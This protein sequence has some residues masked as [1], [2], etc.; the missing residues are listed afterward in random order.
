MGTDLG[1]L[2][3]DRHRDRMIV[4]ASELAQADRRRQAGGAGADDGDVEGH[5]LPR[6]GAGHVWYP[7]VMIGGE[8]RRLL[9]WYVEAG[10]DE[11]IGE[12]P[13][14]RYRAPAA[15]GPAVAPTG[16]PPTSLA[17]PE[18]QPAA[19]PAALASAPAARRGSDL[20]TPETVAGS[21]RELAAASPDLAALAAA[22][23]AFDGCALRETA[24][25]LVF[26]DGNPDAPVMFIGEAPGADE[27]RQGLPF[28]GMAGRLLDR[29]L[30]SIGLDRTSA[31]ITN[32]LPW[33]PP[34]NRKP[35]P[36]EVTICM[37]FL[38]RHIELVAPRVVVLVG[39]TSAQALLE[40]S[41]G[42]TRLRGR[43]HVYGD[44]TGGGGIPARP[45]YHSAYLLRKP[46]MKRDTW[47]DLR[48]I[49]RRLDAPDTT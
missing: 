40:T 34:G 15:P 31:Y 46:G 42:I 49:K 29:M 41:Q 16:T 47:R 48:E 10:A 26:A 7:G 37:P 13:L 32:I 1:T 4:A 36:H 25:N 45:I 2:F 17:E 22:M 3:Q 14:N 18:A 23:A 21:A 9:A 11:A 33:R 30:A 43:W 19:R 27:D 35:T 12:V 28:V 6:R 20:A 5:L 8:A 39:G 24:T 44:E 38:R